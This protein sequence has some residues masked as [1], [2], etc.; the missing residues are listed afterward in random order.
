MSDRREKQA[1]QTCCILLP[2][3]DRLFCS[4]VVRIQLKIQLQASLLVFT[5]LLTSLPYL[6]DLN[7][8]DLGIDSIEIFKDAK[9][10]LVQ[11]VSNHRHYHSTNHS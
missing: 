6:L 10:A 1:S 11:T 2:S 8:I 5:F 4:T 3:A 9:Q 7:N